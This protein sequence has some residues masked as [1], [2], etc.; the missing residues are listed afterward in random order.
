MSKELIPQDNDV[1]LPKFPGLCLELRSNNATKSKIKK[2]KNR[3]TQ[4]VKNIIVYEMLSS[5]L[6]RTKG[7]FEIFFMIYKFAKLF[8][9][10]YL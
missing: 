2:M 3:E 10:Y 9:K 5:T 4:I 8:M 1:W 7:N 6:V